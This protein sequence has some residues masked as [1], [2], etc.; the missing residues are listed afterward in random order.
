MWLYCFHGLTSDQ[1]LFLNMWMNQEMCSYA[2]MVFVSSMVVFV[3]EG[4]CAILNLILLCEYKIYIICLI[5]LRTFFNIANFFEFTHQFVV[6][7]NIE[8]TMLHEYVP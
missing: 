8:L 7:K 1:P 4:F 3:F 5:C 2:D 6:L